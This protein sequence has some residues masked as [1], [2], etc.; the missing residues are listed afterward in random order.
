[1]P[2]L[3]F[4]WERS[5]P[6]LPWT[7]VPYWSTDLLYGLSLFICPTREELHTHAKRLLAAQILSVAVFL[8]FPLRFS[9]PVPHTA[10]LFGWLFARLYGFDQPFNQAPSL[11]LS[12]TVILW[13]EY[14]RQLR[15][16]LLWLTRG[17]MILMGLS[18][19]TTYQHH[20]I[21]LPTGVWVGLLSIALFPFEK[22]AA[23]S[24][25]S[26]DPRRFYI[27]AIYLAGAALLSGLAVFLGGVGWLLL[28]PVGALL[29]VALIYASGRPE[30]FCKSE[31][32]MPA[33]VIWLLGPYLFGAYLNYLFWA[34]R[35]TASDEI[36]S[37]I[38]LGRVPL[39]AGVSIASL[40]DVTAEM[41][42]DASG[43]GYR[44]VPML[45]RLVPEVA[46]LDAAVKALDDL[47]D[48]RPTLGC[49][50]L[51]YARSAAVVAAWLM[52]SGR[53]ASVEESI[54]QIREH[55]PRIV[56]SPADRA[57]LEE[58]RR[59]RAQ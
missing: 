48:S 58:W 52:A 33:P 34:K 1:M 11:H 50:A 6:F 51:G 32:A 10:G 37:G 38:R 14:S 5:I 2:S 7:I 29:L 24:S 49:C 27:A 45:D 30:W 3:V 8:L 57:R 59:T 43:I 55:R 40:V 22:A 16:T 18:T 9:F 42:V 53:A 15:G 44:G 31:G 13:S 23:H 19:L 54:A 26:R 39:R 46:Q 41:P 21:D 35:E 20:F 17:W 56:L 25:P 28:W 4:G 36:V 12:L 47:A